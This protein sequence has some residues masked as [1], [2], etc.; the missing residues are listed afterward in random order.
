MKAIKEGR[1]RDKVELIR[2]AETDED[3]RMLKAN[4]PCV[5]FS[6]EFNK[7]IQK[8]NNLGKEYYS[9]RDD[10]SITK[11]SGLVP[12]DLSLIHI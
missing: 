8:T 7:P 1:Y 9:Y 4:L 2:G 3:K 12:I 11:H 5:L 6:G 10:K